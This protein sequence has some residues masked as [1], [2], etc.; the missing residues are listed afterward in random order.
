[1]GRLKKTSIQHE[2]QIVDTEPKINKTTSSVAKTFGDGVVINGTYILDHPKEVISTGS[3]ALDAAL[4]GGLQVGSFVVMA[5]KPRT[6]KTT[7]ALQFASA[8]QATGRNVKYINAE[9]RLHDR[10]LRGIPG[11]KP[12]EFEV[13]QSRRGKILTAQDNLSIVYSYLSEETDLLVIIDSLSILSEEREILGGIGTETRGGSG[14]IIAQFCRL[15]TPVIPVNSH[16]VIGIAHLYANTSGQGK[17]YLT[18]MGSKAD[19]ALY[20]SLHAEY[21]EP[22]TIGGE[23]GKDIIGQINHWKVDRSPLNHPGEKATSYLRYGQG[24]DEVQEYLVFAEDLSIINKS[25]CWYSYEDIKAQG[26]EK[27]RQAL[28]E[29]SDTWE[30]LKNRVR[31]TMF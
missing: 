15:A 1:M 18:A 3:P 11:L 24:I 14:K 6:G 12:E 2:T 13:I 20:T 17:K 22:W 8:W 23:D 21:S 28:L 5:G 7:T 16:I 31:E 27:F 25:G 10:D 4:G 9:H 19:Y 30:K 29:N 26:A